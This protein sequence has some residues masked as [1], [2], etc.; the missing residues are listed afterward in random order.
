MAVEEHIKGI[1][2]NK[3]ITTEGYPTRQDKTSKDGITWYKEESYQKINPL[4]EHCL[5]FA[6][7][8]MNGKNAGVPDFIIDSS[9]YIKQ[10]ELQ[11]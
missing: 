3:I 1:I 11:T 9:S 4:I 5:S 10:R 7:K 2:T 8:S 6:S